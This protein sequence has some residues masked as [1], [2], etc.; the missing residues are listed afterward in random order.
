VAE[1]AGPDHNRARM[2]VVESPAAGVALRYRS[3]RWYLAARL[4]GMIGFQMQGVAVGW[5][6]YDL[7]RRPI[8]LGYVGLAQ[9]VPSILL[10]LLAGEAADRF[11]RRRL[12]MVCYA[13]LASCTAILALLARHDRPPLGWIYGVLVVV[14]IGRAFAGPAAQALVPNL[15]DAAHF[16]NAVA[17]SSSIWHVAL[18]AG[19]AIGGA[20]YAVVG[21]TWVYLA[22]AAL[23]LIALT[24]VGL[25]PL[26][27]NKRVPAPEGS[28]AKRLLAGLEFVW[29]KKIILGALSLD[30]FAVLLGGAVALLP[31]Y[32]RDILH[33]GPLGLGLL[34]SAPAAGATVTALALAVRPIARR[35]GL[36]MFAGV[37]L[38]G[39][40]TIAFGLSKSFW[41]SLGAL[42]V[43]GSADMVS[44]FIRQNLVQLGTPDGMRGRVSAVNLAFIGVSNELGEFESGAL[45]AWLG[46]VASVVFG[47]VGCC[48]VVLVWMLLFPSLRRVDRLSPSELSAP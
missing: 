34:R 23:Q 44:V 6:V 35:S 13:L 4:F 43:A 12:L 2:T 19:P 26:P 21:A 18:V 38:F 10:S 48:V 45:A 31:V 22:A 8:D 3:F 30:M 17:W 24:A 20:A 32:A 25:L 11:E 1:R 29:R 36:C 42:T 28:A 27:L 15:V 16:P 39:V 7:T 40:A 46:T 37:G 47:G 9:F 41:L 5:Q 33:V 14:G